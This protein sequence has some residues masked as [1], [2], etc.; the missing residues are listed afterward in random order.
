MSDGSTGARSA[1]SRAGTHHD[2]G[3]TGARSAV[4]RAG[5]HHDDGSTGA[6]SAASRAGAHHNDESA[7]CLDVIIVGAGLSGIGAAARL[8]TEHP[9][10][11]FAML[12]MR[13]ASGGTWDLFRYPGIRSDSDM[14]TM[15]YGFR[16]WEGDQTLTDGGQILDYLRQ[17]AR[18][19]DVERRIRFGH[20]VVRASWDSPDALWTV[21]CDTPDGPVT[22]HCSLLWS[23]TG[24]YDYA[25]GYRPA[26]AGEEEFRGR[27]V[28]PQD[29]PA[30]L[31]YD[32][33]RVAV[34]GSGATAVT[35]IPAMA[36]W[37]EHVT[38]IQRSPSYVASRPRR[39]L[40]L[41]A[42]R[43]FLPS[44]TAYRI[45]R[46]RNIATAA[47]TYWLS[48]KLPRLASWVL[49][50]GA[51]RRLPRGYDVDK[52]FRPRYAPWDQRVCLV[53]EGDLFAVIRAGSASVVTGE[54]ARFTPTGVQ[55]STGE[56][57]AADLIV[58]ATGLR[59]LPF[60][61]I[62]LRVDGQR[63]EIPDTMA[64]RAMMLADIPNFAFTIGYTNA[65]WTLKADLVADYVCRLLSRLDAGG[66]RSVVPVRD[67]A[68]P[69]APLL[70]F[71]SGYVVRALGLLPKQGA[72]EPWRL[73]QSYL[74]DARKLRRARIE[75]GVLR[76]KP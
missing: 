71:T 62:E 69:E 60:G 72:R 17:T 15:G 47:T 55:M 68:I 40:F 6:R 73:R 36:E 66:Y 44:A 32:G 56:E 65:T 4:S 22:L 43:K 70:T 34:I 12:E 20:R 7:V 57:V 2:D 23:C 13:E 16:P 42:A 48:R 59:V 21:E 11:S 50:A 30:D 5:T 8:A 67:P 18:E 3:A 54:I 25:G 51:A 39:D 49:R 45:A 52:H 38:M 64:Y 46:G 61:A 33:L 9:Q 29:W 58:T 35:L 37:A 1:V 53:P 24:Y 74:H 14:L 63:I 10:R 75:D 76:F 28:H 26:F 31:V 27:I 19:Y 41:V